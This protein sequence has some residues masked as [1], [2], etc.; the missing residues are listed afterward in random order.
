MAVAT[1]IMD[2]IQD[3]ICPICQE[4]PTD[5][6]TLACDHTFCRCLQKIKRNKSILVTRALCKKHNE[7]LHLFCK[8]DAELL[9]V[10]CEHSP[11]HK[12]HSVHLQEE[13]A[14]EY[15]VGNDL[16]RKHSGRVINLDFLFVGSILLQPP[17]RGLLLLTRP[18]CPPP[19]VTQM[20]P[21]LGSR[22][23]AQ[24]CFQQLV[25]QSFINRFSQCGAHVLNSAVLLPSHRKALPWQSTPLTGVC[26]S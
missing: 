7:N 21:G 4:L 1:V 24:R 8:D 18:A 16:K 15:K 2:L 17:S 14:Q 10:F 13:A 12:G 20:S 9:C 5:L 26:L 19:C 3:I 6:V 11:E 22:K 23:M 25:I